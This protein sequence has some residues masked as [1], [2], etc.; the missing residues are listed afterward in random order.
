MMVWFTSREKS[1]D[2]AAVVPGPDCL[3]ADMGVDHHV[4]GVERQAPDQTTD[5]PMPTQAHTQQGGE[6]GRLKH[7]T[8]ALAR[9]VPADPSHGRTSLGSCWTVDILTWTSPAAA[10]EPAAAPPAWQWQWHWHRSPLPVIKKLRWEAKASILGV[11]ELAARRSPGNLLL[12]EDLRPHS[13]SRSS[14]EG[15]AANRVPVSC[16]PSFLARFRLP[17]S[18]AGTGRQPATCAHRHRWSHGAARRVRCRFF[19]SPMR[20]KQIA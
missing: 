9:A 15:S 5:W 17:R 14:D 12:A 18:Q 10:D 8:P 7:V 19:S 1:I 2:R 3:H 11:R 4:S 16:R 6:T 20:N 13:R